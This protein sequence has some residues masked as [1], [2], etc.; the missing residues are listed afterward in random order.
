M[1]YWL[2]GAGLSCLPRA[3]EGAHS[4]KRSA[5]ER[6]LNEVLEEKMAFTNERDKKNRLSFV[7]NSEEME[8]TNTKYGSKRVPLAAMNE[9]G[10]IVFEAV[11]QAVGDRSRRV[12]ASIDAYP[13]TLRPSVQGSDSA[14]QAEGL[15]PVR[16]V[17]AYSNCRPQN[18][19]RRPEVFNTAS[20]F[21]P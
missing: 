11:P 14:S 6:V 9:D 10:D 5:A 4:F 19:H 2:C 1:Y 18:H 13:R 7:Y 12:G 3:L 8:E 21:I 16:T 17:P 15:T 20:Y